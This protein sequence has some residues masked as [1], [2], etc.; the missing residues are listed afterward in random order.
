MHTVDYPETLTYIYLMNRLSLSL[1]IGLI[2]IVALLIGSVA[3][4]DA[5]FEP[6]VTVTSL[7][8]SH[9]EYSI[10]TATDTDFDDLS[11]DMELLYQEPVSIL[12]RYALSSS[13]PAYLRTINSR[14][15]HEIFVPPQI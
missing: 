7:L 8:S 12:H 14:T 15:H 6:S 10:D 11:A 2:L 13:H 9:D 4:S 1:S 3:V 5:D